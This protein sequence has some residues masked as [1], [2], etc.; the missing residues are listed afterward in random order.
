MVCK[1][2][3]ICGGCKFQHVEYEQQTEMKEE[4]VR[5]L[6]GQ[7]RS[8]LRCKSPWHWR[9]KMEFSFSQN[10]AKDRFLGLMMRGKR[11]RVVT[12]EECLLTSDWFVQTLQNVYAWWE[13]SGLEAY[14][15]PADRGVLRTLTLRE[16][17]QTGEKMAVL[18]VMGDAK[19]EGFAE[20]VGEIDSV[21]V[22]RQYSQKGVPTR[23]EEEVV[24]G[25]DC[26]HE[27][28]LDYTFKV[29]AGSFFQPNTLQAEVLYEAALQDLE[30]VDV[31]FDLYCGTG[32]IGIVASKKAKRVV[33]IEL[34]KEA[35]EAARE[36]VSLN[37]V[38]MEVIEGD[39]EKSLEGL[40]KPDCVILDP[41][42]AGL[43]KKGVD[44]VLGLGAKKIIYISCNPS[45]QKKNIEQMEGYRI[46]W[47]QPV[48]QFPHTPHIEN[49]VCLS[50]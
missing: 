35:V 7:A 48:D 43:T 5:E 32:T 29:R 22:R 45:S 6:F 42:R 1:H 23:F 21:I 46:E 15:P 44:G 37:D 4:M 30:E 47:V 11:G 10:K 41:P 16:G 50:Q 24:Y 26:I 20:A 25:T 13:G 9:N 49:I 28:L 12:L 3:G 19:I 2:F 17:V 31:L 36:N 40:P 27:K 14:F 8:I 18:G 33:G 34:V 38:R 39:V